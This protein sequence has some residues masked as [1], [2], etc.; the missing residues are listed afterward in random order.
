MEQRASR[1]RSQLVLLRLLIHTSDG[2][3]VGI[4]LRRQARVRYGDLDY[5]DCH[6]AGPSRRSYSRRS[7]HRIA[8]AHGTRLCMYCIPASPPDRSIV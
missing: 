3:L 4:A 8:S 1:S 7:A 2:R 6:D 5:G